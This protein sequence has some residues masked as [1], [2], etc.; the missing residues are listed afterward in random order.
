MN[1][2]YIFKVVNLL[3]LLMNIVHIFGV[4]N[5]LKLFMNILYI[6]MDVDEHYIYKC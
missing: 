5:L 6:F 1:I 3:K 2:V 4:A